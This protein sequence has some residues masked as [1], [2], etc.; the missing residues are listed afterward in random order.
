MMGVAQRMKQQ[1]IPEVS[2]PGIMHQRS[3]KLGQNPNLISGFFAPPGMGFFAPPGMGFVVGQFLSADRVQPVPPPLDV[4]AGFISV[5][6][7]GSNDRC[8]NCRGG[9]HNRN[10]RRLYKIRQRTGRDR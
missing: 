10:G 1:L 8:F 5:P 6:H 4:K 7:F 3:R 9:W 2:R